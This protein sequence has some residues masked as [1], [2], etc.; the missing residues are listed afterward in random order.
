M[1]NNNSFITLT[2]S[3]PNLPTNLS[4]NY[5]HFQLFIKRLRKKIKPLKLRFYMA[6]EYGEQFGRPHFHAC[7]FGYSFPDKTYWR[8]TQSKAKIYRSAELEKLWPVGSSSIG[9]VTFESAAYI[10]RYIMKKITTKNQ[11]QEQ[12]KS[13]EIINPDSGEIINRIQEFN[14]M[15]RR[16]GIGATWLSKYKAD[17]YPSGQVLVRGHQSKSPRFYDQQFKKLDAAAYEDLLYG[18]HIES[19]LHTEDNTV[20]RLIVREKVKQAQLGLLPRTID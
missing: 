8:T 13:R 1:H 15:S 11:T 12:K 20:Q 7:I 3:T 9:D 6:G 14:N 19:L 10:A 4:L 2:Y 18:R 16:P 17:V 5:H